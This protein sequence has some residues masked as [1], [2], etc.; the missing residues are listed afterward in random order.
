MPTINFATRWFYQHIGHGEL[1]TGPAVCALCGLRAAPGSMTPKVK[2]FRKTFMDYD[3]QARPAL[4][5]LCAAC[6]W[7]FDHQVLLRSHWYLTATAARVLAKADLLPLLTKHVA[8]A[9]AEDRYYLIA[10]SKKKH[11]ALRGRLNAAG[12]RLLRVNF[13]TLMVDVDQ[14]VLDLVDRLSLLRRYHSWQEIEQNSYLPYAI[15]RWP[16]LR[17]FERLCRQVQPWL[18]SP[19]YT[20]AR[21]L[22]APP[23]G[24]KGEKGENDGT[25][26]DD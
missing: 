22:Y 11:V 10:A 5:D 17:E 3:L 24:R 16:A 19:Q 2:V 25:D 18:R 6:V 15:L 9:P 20:L 8:E 14:A 21:Y 7:Y 4:D 26:E 23:A 12:G 13:E 1:P